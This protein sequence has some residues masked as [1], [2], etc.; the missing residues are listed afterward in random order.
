M[1][2]T[3]AMS[4]VV[5]AQT[6]MTPLPHAVD[7]T[8]SVA[9]AKALMEQHGIR[10]LPVMKDGKL[11]GILSERDIY[12]ASTLLGRSTD[13]IP[14][15]V[16]SICNRDIEV[17]DVDAPASEVAETMA[18]KHLGSML[19]TRHGRLAGIITTVDVCRAYAEVVREN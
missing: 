11:T 18:N 3:N 8:E 5:T 15:P 13:Q 4:D 12:I 6:L 1:P 7:A 16:W 10:H 17:V 2:G 9:T 19:V 14:Q